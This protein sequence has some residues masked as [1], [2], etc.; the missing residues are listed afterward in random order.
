[1]VDTLE[2]AGVL[3]DTVIVYTSDNG[4]LQGE[5][6]FRDAKT[7][8]YEEAIHVPLVVRGP[9][10]PAGATAPQL[11]ANIDLAPTVLDLAGVEGSRVL[12]GESLLPLAGEPSPPPD[13]RAIYLQNGPGGHEAGTETS[14]LGAVPH[15]DG[16][17]VPG[18]TYVEYDRGGR[19]LYDL[20][21]DP[22]QLE[23]RA[24]DPAFAPLERHLADLLE[25]LRNCAGDECREPRF[26]PPG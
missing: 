22:W 25:Q 21:A 5:H 7:L 24:G 4:F 12:D 8:P 6:R 3:D 14:A 11:T 15:W 1:M 26:S 10:F 17:R 19:E 23:N 9:G 13:D 2:Q 16:V 18:Y 20:A